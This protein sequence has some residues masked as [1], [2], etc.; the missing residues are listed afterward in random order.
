MLA[1]L[2]MIGGSGVVAQGPE[3]QSGNNTLPPAQP[4]G[5]SDQL[6]QNVLDPQSPAGGGGP[7]LVSTYFSYQGQLKSS[8]APVN[9]NCDFAFSL[10]DRSGSGEP[11]S[12]GLQVG[13]TQ[14]QTN[15]LVTNGLFNV[16]LNFSDVYQDLAFRGDARWL[17]IAVRCPAGSAQSYTV[18]SPRQPL[19]ATPYALSLRPGANVIG[20]RPDWNMIYASN[21]ATTSWSYGIRSQANAPWGRGVSGESGAAGGMGV[22]GYSVSGGGAGVAGYTATIIWMSTLLTTSNMAS[23]ARARL[24]AALA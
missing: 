14:T 3:P 11:P 21:V 12:G 7:G 1:A 2:L 6:P 5:G 9:G 18:L 4:A 15:V 16:V 10:W 22:Y 17:Q 23:M 19:W 24:R 13:D 20:N 8:N